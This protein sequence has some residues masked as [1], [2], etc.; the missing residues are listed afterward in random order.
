MTQPIQEVIFAE[1]IG[2]P[3]KSIF[4]AVIYEVV[5]IYAAVKKSA[6][7]VEHPRFKAGVKTLDDTLPAIIARNIHTDDKRIK[8]LRF[9]P[10]GLFRLL[11][12]ALIICLNLYGSDG[13]LSSVEASISANSS[14]LLP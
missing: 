2:E 6:D 7:L 1:V 9:L 11:R 14:R 8:R 3:Q 10:V 12:M 13:A 4:K 5:G